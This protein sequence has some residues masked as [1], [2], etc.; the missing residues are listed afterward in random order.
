MARLG[1]AWQAWKNKMPW[2]KQSQ[3]YQVWSQIKQR[4]YNENCRKFKDYGARGIKMDPR[5]RASFKVFEA[6]LT[7]RIG[8][9]PSEKHSLGRINNNKGYWGDNLKWETNS[10]QCR[11]QR[12]NHLV[13]YNGNWMTIAELAEKT[14]RS[15][16]LLQHRIAYQKLMPE[17]AVRRPIEGGSI[18]IEWKGEYHSLSTWAKKLKMSVQTLYSRIYKLGWCVDKSFTA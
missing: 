9:R 7:K 5:W 11:N 1:M 14:G 6:D 4:C 16:K 18:F 12:K 17:E 15:P 2:K 3:L 10:E 13:Y 8:K